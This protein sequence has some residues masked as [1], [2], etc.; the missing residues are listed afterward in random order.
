VADRTSDRDRTPNPS[1]AATD[2]LLEKV[3]P[4][5]EGAECGVL[6]SM[7]IDPH[8]ADIA[9]E[10]LKLEDFYLPRHRTLFALFSELFQ[11]QENLDELYVVSELTRRGQLE[12]VGGKET[13]GRMILATPSAANIEAYCKAVR[14][15][16]V[17]RELIESAG[18]IL[19]LAQQPGATG[20]EDLIDTAEKTIYDI[21]DKRSKD[22]LRPITELMEGVLAEAENV[23]A[24]RREGRTIESPAIPTGYVELDGL[25]SGGFWPGELVVIAGRPSMGKT[26][27][28]INIAR[29]VSVGREDRIKGTA[30]FSLEMPGEQV[31]KNIAAADVRIPGHKMR[32]LDLTEE[33]FKEL[34]SA[35]DAFAKA[36]MFID[37]TSGLTLGQLRARCRRLRHRED[38]RLVVVDYLQLMRGSGARRDSREQEVAELTRGL[39]ALAREM[40]IPLVVLSQLN[41][42]TDKREEG[43]KR[44]Q[45]SDLRESGAIEQDADVVI[46]LYRPEYYDV[47]QNAKNVNIGEAL[48]LKNR[49]GPVGKVRLTFLKEILRFETYQPEH[50]ALAAGD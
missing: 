14:D 30:I 13:I 38:I 48:V 40:E 11:K 4:Y 26:T 21:A 18:K 6:G 28:A 32:R 50:D 20:T 45:L 10:E 41:R 1:A 12:A 47:A 33:E 49:N 5:D 25:L 17:Q 39:K 43:D 42:A 34:L 24:A 29:N 8:A 36:R 2:K 27:F 3:P 31:A 9:I 16:A 23:Q 22:D 19:Q 44:P 37:D 35:R 7:L 15:R 46:M